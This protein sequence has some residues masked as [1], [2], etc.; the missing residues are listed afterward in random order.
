MEVLE[1]AQAVMRSYR[2]DACKLG[3]MIFVRKVEIQP[4]PFLHRCQIRH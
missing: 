3:R 4:N 1:P 2:C